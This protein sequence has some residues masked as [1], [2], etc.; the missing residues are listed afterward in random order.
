MQTRGA[1]TSRRPG[2]VKANGRKA[3]GATHAIGQRIVDGRLQPGELLPTEARLWR[4]LGMNRPSLRG[5]WLA[6]DWSTLTSAET[7]LYA[8]SPLNYCCGG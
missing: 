8:S 5:R 6:K 2:E 1:I 4:E 3:D 7:L